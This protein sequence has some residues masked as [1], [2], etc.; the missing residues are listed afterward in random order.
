[1]TREANTKLARDVL[2][3]AKGR[4]PDADVAVGVNAG[5]TANTRFARNEPSTNGDVEEAELSIML[6]FGRKHATASTNQ[7]DELATATAIDR[8]A[9]MARLSPEDVEWMPPLGPQ[10]FA[11]IKGAFDPEVGG[12]DATKRATSV[13]AAIAEAKAAGVLGAGYLECAAT[14][15]ILANSHGLF[16]NH[17]STRVDMTMTARTVDGTGSGWAAQGTTRALELDAAKVGHVAADKG[18]RSSKARTLEPGKYT[19][20]L[21]PAAVAELLDFFIGA[22]DARRADEGRSFFS[23]PGGGTKLGDKLFPDSI[24]L[25]SDPTNAETPGPPFD[26]QGLPLGRV[27]WVDRG[28]VSALAYSRYWASKQGKSPTGRRDTFLLRGGTVSRAEDL[29]AGVKRGL[30][31]TRFWYTRWLEPKAMSI[32]GLTRDG[33]FLVEDGRVTG[34]VNNFRFN[35]SPANVLANCD[36]MTTA[37]TR[38]PGDEIWRV[39]TLR[40]HDFNMA[41]VSA[42]V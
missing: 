17:D 37:T 20:I 26:R 27:A 34:P 39:P 10:E 21:E 12:F 38:V 33:V 31:V 29:L 1:M 11:K 30:L 9:S 18:V 8:A 19:V 42:A 36:G 13:G 22:L 7:T 40:T 2:A 14:E 41:S 32:T 5:W 16:G 6:A 3:L 35:E 23:K 24:T 28:V 25:E 4:Y 15:R